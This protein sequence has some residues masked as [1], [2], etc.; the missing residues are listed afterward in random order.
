MSK[1]DGLLIP[2]KSVDDFGL[3][4]NNNLFDGDEGIIVAPLLNEPDFST[5]LVDILSF[6]IVDDETAKQQFIQMVTDRLTSRGVLFRVDGSTLMMELNEAVMFDYRAIKEAL[7]HDTSLMD[8][9]VDEIAR[10]VGKLDIDID[11]RRRA[12]NLLTDVAGR[13]FDINL[14]EAFDNLTDNGDFDG[15]LIP[16]KTCQS[17]GIS[18]GDYVD[19]SNRGIVVLPQFETTDTDGMIEV[20]N[21][22]M[23]DLNHEDKDALSELLADH[24]KALG[25]KHSITDDGVKI[26][27]SRAIIL[28]YAFL[29][30]KGRN[31]IAAADEL[32][33]DI[34]KLPIDIEYRYQAI[35]RLEHS[36]NQELIG[37]L[38]EMEVN[39]YKGADGNDGASESDDEESIP[40]SDPDNNPNMGPG[41]DRDDEDEDEDDFDPDEEKPS[42]PRNGAGPSSMRPS[43]V[44]PVIA[45]RVYQEPV[46]PMGGNLFLNR[47]VT[48]VSRPVIG[49]S[50]DVP[51][52]V[53]RPTITPSAPT[54]VPRPTITPSVPTVV[55]RPTITPSTPVVRPVI[56]PSIPTPTPVVRPVITPLIPTPT[57]VVRP[58]ITPSVPTPSPVAVPRPVITSSVPTPIPGVVQRPGSGGTT[59]PGVVQRPGSGGTTIP[60]P[61][62]VPRPP[63]GSSNVPTFR[64]PLGSSSIPAPVM[65]SVSRPTLGSSN[66]PAPVMTSVSRPTLGSSSIPAPVMTSVSRPTLGSS[67]IP[68]P[69]SQ[70]PV[71]Y[72]GGTVDISSRPPQVLSIGGPVPVKTFRDVALPRPGVEESAPP[73]FVSGDAGKP[74]TRVF[75]EDIGNIT[76]LYTL[77]DGPMNLSQLVSS[78]SR[79]DPAASYHQQMTASTWGSDLGSPAEP[80]QTGGTQFNKLALRRATEKLKLKAKDPRQPGDNGDNYARPQLKEFAEAVGVYKSTASVPDIAKAVWNYYYPNE[81]V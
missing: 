3:D 27:L 77:T 60:T 67:G 74:P 1:L 31:N 65:T 22:D 16:G 49:K 32:A 45:P 28:G 71:P 57:P 54:V 76:T 8:K 51:A 79:Q 73:G 19:D 37:I 58:A 25:F 52:V 21:F 68:A 10:R 4:D 17:L 78:G 20:A 43:T 18:P 6:D 9:G 39:E 61:V 72:P 33:A 14:N 48:P 35:R 29:L 70:T 66:V 81:P 56:T 55:P 12:L 34:A 23:L 2:G 38:D 80:S 15:V 46:A 26:K 69:V 62:G 11:T 5:G 7:S 64:P 47:N 44:A 13:S 75:P 40:D 59:I 50:P 36:S 24:L 53:P 63:L 30:N 41:S 42:P